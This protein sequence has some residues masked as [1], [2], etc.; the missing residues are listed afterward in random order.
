MYRLHISNRARKE[1]KIM[2]LLK[3][4]AVLEALQDISE[5]P[6]LGKPLNRNLSGRFSYRMGVN[7]IIYIINEDDRV[8]EIL[9]A[10]HRSIVYG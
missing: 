3:K 1:L 5:E 2:S 7:R 6:L 8:V 10:G 9:S 4:E